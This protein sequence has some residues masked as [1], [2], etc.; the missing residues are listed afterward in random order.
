MLAVLTLGVALASVAPVAWAG[1]NVDPSFPSAEVPAAV[2][3]TASD[4]GIAGPS[5]T[6]SLPYAEN[7]LEN[8]EH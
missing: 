7:R 4:S 2:V 6:A 3:A 5:V 8:R 1:D